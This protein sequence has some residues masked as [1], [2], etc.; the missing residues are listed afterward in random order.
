MWQATFQTYVSAEG[1]IRA[2]AFD[3]PSLI[4]PTPNFPIPA[5]GWVMDYPADEDWYDSLLEAHAGQNITGISVPAA[6][7]LAAQADAMVDPR[8]ATALCQRAEQLS[9][10]SV[11]W[12][13]LD[14]PDDNYVVS[15]R[16]VGYTENG[17][18]LVTLAIQL[19]VVVARGG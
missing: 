13:V 9:A 4:N 1:S 8:A 19:S 12:I 17:A 7:A 14:Q 6:D 3:G 18:C 16:V 11:A 5:V 2:R 15:P 10:T